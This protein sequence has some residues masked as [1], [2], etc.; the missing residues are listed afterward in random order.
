MDVAMALDELAELESQKDT[1]MLEKRSMLQ[2]AIPPEVQ[3]ELDDI[4]AEFEGKSEVVDARIEDMKKTITMM[5]LRGGQTV[6]GT[7]KSAVFVKGR[8]KWDGK[9]LKGVAKTIPG[10]MDALEVGAPSVQ[11]R[12]NK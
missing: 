9:M 4:E 3:K 11:F 7:Y 10:V 2:A 8:E 12:S 1:L 5:V 6:K